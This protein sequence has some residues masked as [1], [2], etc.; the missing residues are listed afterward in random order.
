VSCLGKVPASV[1]TNFCGLESMNQVDRHS[2]GGTTG[3]GELQIVLEQRRRMIEP[4]S[5]VFSSA[6]FISGSRGGSGA[7]SAP[8]AAPRVQHRL[9]APAY[10]GS[11]GATIGTLNNGSPTVAPQPRQPVFKDQYRYVGN[12]YQGIQPRDRDSA[13][14]LEKRM[15]DLMATNQ[16]LESQVQTLNRNL[17]AKEEH[18]TFFEERNLLLAETDTLLA[19]TDQMDRQSKRNAAELSE[20]AAQRAEFAAE[21]IRAQL[22]SELQSEVDELRLARIEDCRC[23]SELMA[24]LSAARS[25]QR[26]P[27]QEKSENRRSFTAESDDLRRQINELSLEVVNLRAKTQSQTQQLE[28]AEAR[29]IEATDSLEIERVKAA[30]AMTK[31]L[32][33]QEELDQANERLQE[34][35]RQDVPVESR[36]GGSES[37]LRRVMTQTN[38]SS[39]DL[40]N[41]VKAVEALVEEAQRELDRKMYRERRAAFENLCNAIEKADDA[42]LDAALVQARK[43]CVDEVDIKRGEEKLE[44][45]RSMTEEQKAARVSRELE[46]QRKKDAFLL[47]KKD[48][49][50]ELQ[51]FIEGFE[52]GVRWMD[53]R[54]YAGRTLYKAA[55]ELHSESVKALLARLLGL[56][57]DKPKPPR[58]I[59]F[60]RQLSGE[61]SPSDGDSSRK[62]SANFGMELDAPEIQPEVDGWNALEKT[63]EDATSTTQVVRVDA[64]CKTRPYLAYDNKSGRL[65]L[66]YQEKPLSE[67]EEAEMKTK[68]FRAVVQDDEDKLQDILESVPMVIWE[69]WKNKA[70]K[71]LL[72]LSQE[73][74]A[75]L[76]YSVIAKALGILREQ[77]RD[78]FEY[79]EAV[80][81][82]QTGDVQARR[83]TVKEDT[84]EEADKILVE[85]WDGDDEPLYVDR[86]QV[87]KSG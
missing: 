3:N 66:C 82:F 15:R 25:L 27:G 28:A 75:S 60:N 24:E 47:V 65:N 87:R 12:S 79:G 81:V 57:D 19:E 45:L 10:S 67:T 61:Q 34:Q 76:A 70:D 41:A 51:A 71:D 13:R 78:T 1:E 83:A 80:W 7:S 46:G 85:Y 77:T 22:S 20:L 16:Q 52:E 31:Q 44:E 49:A 32:E 54:D 68:A 53:W 35:A 40:R 30:K 63:R 73:R 64:A 33:L 18:S 39:E 2:F 8:T 48:Q 42:T 74:G 69:K 36:S 17:A 11:V 37:Q 50:A 6:Q 14:D 84:P 58:R 4:N 62:V 21:E 86:P 29:Y 55:Q 23:K 56:K 5:A 38:S 9:S 26:E 72:T 43:A 59:G